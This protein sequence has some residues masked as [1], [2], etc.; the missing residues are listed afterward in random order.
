M[1]WICLK[2]PFCLFGNPSDTTVINLF[3]IYMQPQKVKF[4]SVQI[5]MKQVLSYYMTKQSQSFAFI[6]LKV[7]SSISICPVNTLV[8]L[9]VDLLVFTHIAGTS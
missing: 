9:Y 5:N 6:P 4:T 7:R 3:F 8:N 2:L 1:V